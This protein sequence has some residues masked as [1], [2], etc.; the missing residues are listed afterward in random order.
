MI[1]KVGAG[2][3]VLVT[4]G[5]GYVGSKLVPELLKLGYKVTVLDIYIFG[6]DVFQEYRQDPNLIEVKGDLRDI[7]FVK[8]ALK[9]IDFVIH[10]ACISNDPSFELDPDLGKS[11]NYDAFRPLI[12][13]SKV[14]GVRRFIYASS[15]SVYGFKEDLDVTENVSLEPMTDYSKYK[16][17]CETVLKE[18]SEPGF[19]TLILRPA[20][21]CGYARRLRLD[22]TVNIL[23]NLAINKGEITVFGGDQLRPNIHIDDIVELYSRCLVYDEGLIDGKI[24]NVGYENNSVMRI[25]EM[26]RETLGNKIKIKRT[27][28]DDLR[29]YHIS[30]EKIS[31]E[32]GFNP[33]KTIHDAVSDLSNAFNEGRVPNSLSDPKYFNVKTMQGIELH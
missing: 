16:V 15:S 30:S 26:V 23:T 32:L 18:E 14:A 2:K 31:N 3:N 24:F 17:W 22:L 5:A 13:A 12:K 20:T 29:S 6:N 10:L 21:V 9:G 25:A 11:I 8:K 7:N 33:V 1:E 19:A 27:K 4:G 28:T